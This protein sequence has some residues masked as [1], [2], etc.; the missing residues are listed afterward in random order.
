MFLEAAGPFGIPDLLAIVGDHA[1][2]DERLQLD[3]PPL[4]NQVDAGVVSAAAG[5]A[6]RTVPTLARRLGWTVDTVARRLPHLLRTGALIPA[7]PETYIRPRQLRPVGRL[8]AVEAKVKDWR[9]ALRQAR[10][11]SAWCDCY[12]IV[13]PSLGSASLLGLLEAVSVDGGGLLVG[14]KWVK[15]P[16][17]GRRTAAQRLW[18]SEHVVAAFHD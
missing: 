2:L 9:R 15:R 5:A 17:I 11:Y 4:L 7:G 18:G 14:G 6:P 8:Y 12:V 13:M 10:T 16:T 1:L 3:V